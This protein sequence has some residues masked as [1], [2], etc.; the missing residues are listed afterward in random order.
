M[1]LPS[2]Q[3]KNSITDTL[4]GKRLSSES[5]STTHSSVVTR[6]LRSVHATLA[7]ASYRAELYASYIR[8]TVYLVYT[9]LLV[10]RHRTCELVTRV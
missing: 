10:L 4:K 8:A 3:G 5:S 7:L 9:E 2:K 1:V 6:R